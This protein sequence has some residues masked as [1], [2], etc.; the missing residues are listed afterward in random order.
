[1]TEQFER[2]PLTDQLVRFLA[3]HEKG[4][5]VSYK[6]LSS[7]VGQRI[8][9]L[10]GKLIY[11]RHILERDHAQVWVAIKPGIAIRRL[12]DLE[13]AERL[14]NWHLSGARRKL[15]R[16]GN[17]SRIVEYTALSIDE[18]ARFSVN[19]I[20]QQLAL[21]S[22]SKPTWNRLQKVARGSSNDLPSFNI[23]EWAF[24]LIPRRK[25]AGK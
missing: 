1:M 13:I 19:S 10:N 16:G 3:Q 11:A 9:P 7:Q 4:T 8:G 22:L 25:D 5:E 2:S 21:Q 12:T 24:S 20:Q 6:E 18:Q 23:A 17:E 15:K 14:P